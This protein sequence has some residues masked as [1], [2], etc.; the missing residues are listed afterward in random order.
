MNEN[1][2]AKYTS[3][4]KSVILKELLKW[5]FGFNPEHLRFSWNTW[6][7]ANWNTEEVPFEHN[8]KHLLSDLDHIWKERAATDKNTVTTPLQA[9]MILGGQFPKLITMQDRNNILT[10]SGLRDMALARTGSAPTTTGTTHAA[11]GTGTTSEA[12]TDI[13]METEIDRKEFDTDGD[14]D[15][16]A[17]TERYAMAFSYT[18]LG[19]V[20]REITEAGLLTKASV[21]EL[22]AR[23]TSNAVSMT[24]ARIMTIQVDVSHANGTVV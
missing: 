5:K 1:F 18:D 4:E 10:T 9:Q 8:P 24:T 22:I 6:K 3:K 7:I 11:V 12:L 16:V 2:L 19:S 13:I 17:A 21:G 14:R 23:V 15:S 20:D